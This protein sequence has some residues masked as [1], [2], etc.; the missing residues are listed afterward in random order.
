[1]EGLNNKGGVISSTLMTP[2]ISFRCII[3]L[4][5]GILSYVIENYPDNAYF[6]FDKLKTLDTIGLIKMLYNR[7]QINQ[8]SIIVSNIKYDTYK[9]LIEEKE[10]DI[11]QRS[12][13]TEIYNLIQQFKSSGD[14]KPSILYYTKEELNYIHSD[15]ILNSFPC[16]DVNDVTEEI[17][18]HYMQFWFK[19]VEETHKFIKFGLK[20]PARSYYIADIAYNIKDDNPDSVQ[21]DEIITR[22]LFKGNAINTYSM[23]RKDIIGGI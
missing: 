7:E 18:L 13:S 6:N 3:D 12:L 22:A 5:I 4:D 20:H 1:M 15:D 21:N 11:I 10:E 2:L 19:D 8:L 14:I 9:E 23:Y 16:I 17:F